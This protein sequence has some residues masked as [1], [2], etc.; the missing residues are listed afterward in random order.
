MYKKILA[1]IF[2]SGILNISN[3]ENDNKAPSSTV[4]KRS[5]IF[6]PGYME[7]TF[8]SNESMKYGPLTLMQLSSKGFDALTHASGKYKVIA[9]ILY[10]LPQSWFS[11]A[12]NVV[13]H[14][15]GHAR[16]QASYQI[17]YTYYASH[18]STAPA[19]KTDYAYGLYL[20][21][22]LN[23][24]Y[25]LDGAMTSAISTPKEIGQQLSSVPEIFVNRFTPITFNKGRTALNKQ[26]VGLELSIE[27]QSNLNNLS[28][29]FGLYFGVGGLNNNTRYAQQISDL[30]FKNN[31]HLIYFFDYF[32]GKTTPLFYWLLLGSYGDVGSIVDSY[33]KQNLSIKGPDIAFG[34][35][36][37]LLLSSTTWAFAYSVF[38]EL[39]KGNFIVYAPV[40]HGWRLP[41]L[42]FYLTS[43]GL[44]FEVITGYQFNDNWYAGLSTEVVYKGR[45]AYE[46]GPTLGY[47]FNTSIGRINL[48][49][50]IIIGN[51]MEMGS[52][53]EAEWTSSNKSWSVGLKYI[54]H[55]ALTLVGERNIPFLTSGFLNGVEPSLT[56]HEANITLSYN[57]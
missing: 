32:V 53:I 44:S 49:G 3:A 56:N 19:I 18:A 12:N 31:G 48:S 38:T 50:Q 46:F 51:D 16:A 4:L 40:W 20:Q 7:H 30:I 55:N 54:Y 34:S 9:G 2:L 5:I 8:N 22:F 11:L 28:T 42:N 26:K 14:E 33:K 6:T 10:L 52:N 43:Q 39:P 1:L 25:F 37:S 13:Y 35:T 36:L 24:S 27:E 41:D 47:S 57:Y 23:P 45:S 15:F 21:K 29:D 17:K